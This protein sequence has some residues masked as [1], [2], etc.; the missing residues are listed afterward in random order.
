MEREEQIYEEPPL[1]RAV[2][3]RGQQGEERGRRYRSFPTGIVKGL[4]LFGRVYAHFAILVHFVAVIAMLVLADLKKNV[5]KEFTVTF[6]IYIL[7]YCVLFQTKLLLHHKICCCSRNDRRSLAYHICNVFR[8]WNDF[9]IGILTI[10]LVINAPVYGLFSEE[11]TTCSNALYPKLLLYEKIFYSN[12][13]S[14]LAVLIICMLTIL[15]MTLFGIAFNWQWEIEPLHNERSIPSP[16][17]NID[18]TTLQQFT[19]LAPISVV[20]SN[21]KRKGRLEELK[22]AEEVEEES[23]SGPK[24]AICLSCFKEEEKESGKES[25]VRM[26]NCLHYFCDE[27]ISIYLL[28]HVGACPICKQDITV[29]R[30]ISFIQKKGEEKGTEEQGKEELHKK[31]GKSVTSA[32]EPTKEKEKRKRR[33]KKQVFISKTSQ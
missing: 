2:E 30:K 4:V 26:L 10:L 33:R 12:L 23:S 31:E 25:N 29:A 6:A 3:E 19:V 15:A 22:K 16:P 24:C 11:K 27:C 20:D 9:A 17:L 5:C 21:Y 1:R 32:S 28:H 14:T 8:R 7:V 13:I 18:Q